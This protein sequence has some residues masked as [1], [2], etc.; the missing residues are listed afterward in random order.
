MKPIELQLK[1][2]LGTREYNRFAEQVLYPAIER[3]AKEGKLSGHDLARLAHY[4]KSG[5]AG[6]FD[7]WAA[8]TGD[9][10]KHSLSE[11]APIIARKRLTDDCS[12]DLFVKQFSD[13]ESYRRGVT[14]QERVSKLLKG[15]E[16]EGTVPE[17]LYLNPSKRVAIMPLVDG[18]LL[19][20]A[21]KR[22]D[23]EALL[24]KTIDTYLAVTDAVEAADSFKVP[25][26]SGLGKLLADDFKL[27]ELQD[28]TTFFARHFADDP[29]FIKAYEVEIGQPLRNE[30]EAH[31]MFIHGDLH[32]RNIIVNGIPVFIDWE[33]AGRGF[34]E[35]DL[36]KLLAKAGVTPEEERHIVE[37][38]ARSQL[39]LQQRRGLRTRENVDSAVWGSLA[40]YRMNQITQDVLTAVRYAQRAEKDPAHRERLQ[41]MALAAYNIAH[42]H[43]DQGE[44]EMA[45]LYEFK[46]RL[47]EH[48]ARHQPFL[49]VLEGAEL[50]QL[51]SEANPHSTV[52]QENLVSHTIDAGIPHTVD[53]QLRAKYLK[54]IKKGIRKRDWGKIA[55]LGAAALVI[56]GLAGYSGHKFFEAKQAQKSAQ[57]R[58]REELL[59]KLYYSDFTTG[60]NELIR[61]HLN[62][63]YSRYWDYDEK[64]RKPLSR[65]SRLNDSK[66]IDALCAEHNIEPRLVDT[67]YVV[68]ECFAN[69]DKSGM[70]YHGLSLFD[71]YRSWAVETIDPEHNL[72]SG[73]ARLSRLFDKYKVDRAAVSKACKDGVLWRNQP[74]GFVEALTEFYAYTKGRTS[75]SGA[76]ED[77]LYASDR[78]LSPVPKAVHKIVYNI[79]RGGP[80]GDETGSAWLNDPP[81]DFTLK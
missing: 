73:L 62:G 81:K 49:R 8:D 15:T 59:E 32:K 3:L 52:S 2:L 68:N 21:L 24:T 7:I 76:T 60:Y 17:Q 1:E 57:E 30:M 67:V 14:V 47:K 69:L 39:R 48:M 64:N 65:I 6:I 79:L 77:E 45:T 20:D 42:Q 31:P 33:H 29:A 58:E 18:E 50:E 11:G 5:G 35:F 70:Q 26:R 56:L 72:R 4:A 46:R 27:P 66:K 41:K 74:A 10:T 61:A 12:I 40:V 28:F 63:G 37:H 43:I 78:N 53:D 55:K 54:T 13:D 44:R 71:P 36:N 34:M 19:D 38:A 9:A 22:G 25:D 23:K 80:D 16:L 75:T 51:L